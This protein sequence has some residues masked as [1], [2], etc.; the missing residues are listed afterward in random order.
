M[1]A[2]TLLQ[3]P[4]LSV[5][6]YRCTATAAEK[7]YAEHHSWYSLAYVRKGSF[8]CCTQGKAFD[9]VP[10]SLFVGFPGDEY[11]CTHDHHV[12]GDECLSFSF[13]PDI[14]DSVEGDASAWRAGV[15]PPLAELM[16]L[17]ELA[18][19]SA[20]GRN[21]LAL[22]EA[23]ALLVSRFLGV[24]SGTP[25]GSSPTDRLVKRR[26]SSN[27]YGR[28][29]RRIIE[30]AMRIGRESR[31]R[32]SLEAMASW[33]GLSPFHFLRVFTRTLGLTPHQ[34]LIRC[35]LADAARLLGAR[36]Q[37]VT[38]IA[39]DVGFDD[40]SHFIRT[41]RRATGVAPTLFRELAGGER[42]D[43]QALLGA[44]CQLATA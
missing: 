25:R 12:C 7:P 32:L 31:Q 37:P 19:G 39:F 33:A 15:L 4:T 3:T 14:A 38:S 1:P 10:G 27:G 20:D 36:E 13:A 6:D 16:P 8:G 22:E 29:R 34:Y 9:L 30:T 18:Q 5:I 28:V 43:L 26:R 42:A 44:R 23:G 24:V 35:R 40:L 41:F 11:I 21:D 2:E 17:G